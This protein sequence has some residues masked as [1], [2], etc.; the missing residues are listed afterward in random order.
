MSFPVHP[1]RMTNP[2]T[3]VVDMSPGN[4]PGQPAPPPETLPDLVAA[5]RATAEAEVT[6][7]TEDEDGE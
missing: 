2:N 6:K 1:N 7:A 3:R 4:G 5:L